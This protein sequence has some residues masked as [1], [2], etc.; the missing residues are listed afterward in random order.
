MHKVICK[1][2]NRSL[3]QYLLIFDNVFL[4]FDR[5]A[6]PSGKAGACKA[7]IPSSNLGATLF[8]DLLLVIDIRF[9]LTSNF[10]SATYKIAPETAFSSEKLEA[11]VLL[12]KVHPSSIK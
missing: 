1:E 8:A 2:T 9:S 7:P 4:V 10:F 12:T 3:T 6:W 11:V 5:V